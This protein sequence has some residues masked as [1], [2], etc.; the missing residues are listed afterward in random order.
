MSSGWD[1]QY[2]TVTEQVNPAGFE[3]PI[4]LQE[5]PTPDQVLLFPPLDE[6]RRTY[7]AAAFDPDRIEV[8]V[9]SDGRPDGSRYYWSGLPGKERLGLDACRDVIGRHRVMAGETI[10]AYR[11]VV[12]CDLWCGRYVFACDGE[13]VCFRLVACTGQL[14]AGRAST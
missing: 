7:G 2:W 3:T 5:F 6:A 1:G 14:D 9:W 4:G 13:R 12:V 10:P 11:D 8:G